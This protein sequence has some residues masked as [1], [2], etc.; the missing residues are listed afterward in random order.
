LTE[1]EQ[2]IRD[3]LNLPGFVITGLKAIG[4]FMNVSTSTI[5]RWGVRFRGRTDTLLCFPLIMFPTG[6]GLG[7][8]YKTNTS[9]IAAWML[10]WAIIDARER[11]TG[12][13]RKTITIDEKESGGRLAREEA[14]PVHEDPQPQTSPLPPE[15]PC[16]C[17]PRLH[18]EAAKIE[19]VYWG[20]A[21]IVVEPSPEPMTT[22]RPEGC[23][24][25]TG[26]PCAV[27]DS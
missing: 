19:P 8:T 9:L 3:L 25:G 21:P 11:Q 12:K 14:R 16:P 17:S 24:C 27:C 7:W 23:T 10:R 26:I 22:R 18:P 15:R 4:K 5:S 20:P 13:P 6:K 1:E 2:A